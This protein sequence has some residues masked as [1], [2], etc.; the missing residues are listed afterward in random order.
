MKVFY[1]YS[2]RSKLGRLCGENPAPE[3]GQ[4][5]SNLFKNKYLMIYEP[6]NSTMTPYCLSHNVQ[7]LSSPYGRPFII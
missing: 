1:V 6:C 7:H 3:V 2:L 4:G 5:L